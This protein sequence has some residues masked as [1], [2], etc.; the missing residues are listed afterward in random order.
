DHYVFRTDDGGVS[1]KMLS[2]FEQSIDPSGDIKGTECRLFIQSTEGI[3]VSVDGGYS[4]KSL[5]GPKNATDT[6][7]SVVGDNIYAGDNDGTVWVYE[8]VESLLNDHIALS[9]GALEIEL[10]PCQQ[11]TD[12][13]LYFQKLPGCVPVR[14]SATKLNN[15]ALPNLRLLNSI[16]NQKFLNARRDSLR[17]QF[18]R[19]AVDSGNANIKI[20]YQVDGV[21]HDTI[22]RIHFVQRAP[23]GISVVRSTIDAGPISLC[24]SSAIHFDILNESCDLVRFDSVRSGY[25]EFI[26]E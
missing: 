9:F 20:S 1:W 14:L 4:W 26:L 11:S 8:S 16:D 5:G 22:V 13:V 15:G 24:D 10:A 21:V 23:G 25:G 6:R 7:F 2:K 19:S 17:L 3:S 12:T 18:V